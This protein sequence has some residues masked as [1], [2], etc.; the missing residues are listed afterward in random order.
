VRDIYFGGGM[1]GLAGLAIA[2][3]ILRSLTLGRARHER[4]EGDGGSPLMHKSIMEIGFWL[5]EPIVSLLAALRMTPNMVTLLSLVPA[6]GAAVA[7][8][9]GWF[10]LAA[11]LGVLSTLC[12]VLDGLLARRLG[13]SS[14]AGEVIDASVDRYVEFLFLAGITFYYRTN[15]FMLVLGLAA[16]FGSYTVSYTTAKAE[17]MGVKPPRGVMRRAERG[18]YTLFAA[19]FTS[20]THAV[21]PETTTFLL[22][23]LP[24][25]LM[26]ALVG[27]ATNIS[28]PL[29]LR[30]VMAALREKEAAAVPG[31][32]ARAVTPPSAPVSAEP[33]RPAQPV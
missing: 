24:M 8:G 30:A 15:A 7:S 26:L 32:L 14:D 23:D 5:A 25:L 3:Y 1:L 19:A 13:T 33:A 28:A 20:V 11:G 31:G 4:V 29:R 10:G 12:D 27:G 21:F 9:N 22:R 2:G 6:L 17:A 18:F 16:I